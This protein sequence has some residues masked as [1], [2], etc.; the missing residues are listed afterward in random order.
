M[1]GQKTLTVDQPV[2]SWKAGDTGSLLEVPEYME[3]AGPWKNG[4]EPQAK[5]SAQSN[6]Y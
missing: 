6:G 1:A 3:L 2:A 4:I 5:K